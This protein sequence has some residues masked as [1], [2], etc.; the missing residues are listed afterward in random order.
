MT[1]EAKQQ[2]GHGGAREGAGRPRKV[3]LPEPNLNSGEAAPA[4][5]ELTAEAPEPAVAEPQRSLDEMIA[6]ALGNDELSAEFLGALY[7]ALDQAVGIADETARQCRARSVDPLCRDGIAE[8]G[9][10]EDQEFVATRLRN[11]ATPLRAKYQAALQREQAADWE[12]KSRQIELMVVK[13][14]RIMLRRYPKA[15]DELV[16]VFRLVKAV[17]KAVDE[18]NAT[19]PIGVTRRLAKTELVARD[20]DGFY[21]TDVSIVEKCVLPAFVSHGSSY[22]WPPPQR[23][24]V[25]DYV[26]SMTAMLRGAPPP[27]TEEERIAAAQQ[28]IAHGEEM[29]REHQRLNA[30]AHARAE[31]AAAERRRL[32]NGGQ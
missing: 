22:A 9:K 8:R 19:A 16:E 26:E 13:T 17:D 23:N 21:S 27:P 30:E 4:K 28:H 12:L 32:A 14:A 20:I 31:A 18:I 10:A 1:I 15:V 25:V 24:W 29:E 11:A 2:F 3:E 7:A 5:L 6:E